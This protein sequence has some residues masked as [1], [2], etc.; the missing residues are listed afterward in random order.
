MKPDHKIVIIILAMLTV[1]SFRLVSDNISRLTGRPSD[2]ILGLEASNK[3]VELTVFG[4]KYHI[5]PDISEIKRHA[6]NFTHDILPD[7]LPL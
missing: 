4:D 1:L 6:V 5:S 2:A 7:T 3:A